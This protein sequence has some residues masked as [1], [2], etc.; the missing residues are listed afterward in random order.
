M[1]AAPS[2]Q[3]PQTIQASPECSVKRAQVRAVIAVANAQLSL[4]CSTPGLCRRRVILLVCCCFP[5][6]RGLQRC[7]KM[8]QET[9]TACTRSALARCAASDPKITLEL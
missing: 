7:I 3:R 8:R 4:Q 2:R 1:S 5:A 6:I 9:L